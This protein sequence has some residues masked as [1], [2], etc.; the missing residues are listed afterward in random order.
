MI[1]EILLLILTISVVIIGHNNDQYQATQISSEE[2]IQLYN[3]LNQPPVFRKRLFFRN[4]LVLVHQGFK[5]GTLEK[6]MA[7]DQFPTIY[8]C[9]K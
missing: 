5:I 3:Q 1:I 6:H 4:Y 2:F 9:G 8:N 7:L